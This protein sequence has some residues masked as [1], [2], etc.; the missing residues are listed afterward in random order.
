MTV[1][2]GFIQEVIVL[3]PIS[4]EVSTNADITSKI[5][6][7]PSPSCL[8]TVAT[9]NLLLFLNIRSSKLSLAS[10]EV[11]F[12]YRCYSCQQWQNQPF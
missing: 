11:F 10:F 9:D 5:G 6:L 1:I 12:D 2:A 8:I 7:T 3:K 4:P